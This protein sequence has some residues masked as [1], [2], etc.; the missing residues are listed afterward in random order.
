MS[1]TLLEA[2]LFGH[3]KG[4]FTG[5]DHRRHGR[6]MQ[7]DKGTLFLDEIGEIPL[8]MQSKILRAIQEREIQRLGS[9]E[10]LYVDV[11]IIANNR[12]LEE[13]VRQSRFR[14]DLYDRLNVMN[15]LF[16]PYA[17][18]WRIVLS[19]PNIFCKNTWRKTAKS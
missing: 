15:I 6:F 16:H 8:S 17:N 13:E 1:E 4:T 14:E 19:L 5:A 18:G 2:E 10:V 11:R 12:D 9:D 3:E 7:A